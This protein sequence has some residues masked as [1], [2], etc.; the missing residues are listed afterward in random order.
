MQCIYGQTELVDH[1]EFSFYPLHE[2]VNNLT[3]VIS[4]MCWCINLHWDLFGWSPVMF[5]LSVLSP[6]H[7][8]HVSNNYNAKKKTLDYIK[9]ITL[10]ESHHL[11]LYCLLCQGAAR[12]KPVG[13][14]LNNEEDKSGPIF[15]VIP[16]AKEQ[17]IKEEKQLKV[18]DSLNSM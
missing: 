14:S 13:K 5:L 16:N 12:K 11:K 9:Q 15:I 17:R 7:H 6:F 8:N 2:C 1:L 4:A 10:L 3:S 18:P